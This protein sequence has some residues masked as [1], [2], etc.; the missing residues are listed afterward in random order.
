MKHCNKCGAEMPDFAKFC[1][2]CGNPFEEEQVMKEEPQTTVYQQPMWQQ[3]SQ[4]QPTTVI[5]QSQTNSVGVVGF[6]FSLLGLFTFYIPL[7]GWIIV[8]I[9]GCCCYYGRKKEPK[10][11]AIAGT[12][13]TV[14][15]TILL[16]LCWFIFK[17]VLN[18]MS[19]LF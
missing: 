10:G 15:N 19:N 4:Q 1:G 7:L 3:Q 8:M 12:V 2:E 14:I 11:L 13:I 9:G 16:L 5:I 18:S 17:S 6:V